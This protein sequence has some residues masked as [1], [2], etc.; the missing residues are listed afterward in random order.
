MPR[1]ESHPSKRPAK[2]LGAYIVVAFIFA[3][4]IVAFAASKMS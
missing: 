4:V 2:L 1:P 3:A